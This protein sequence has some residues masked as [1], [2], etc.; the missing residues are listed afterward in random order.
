MQVSTA[1]LTLVVGLLSGGFLFWLF[2]R[3]K[4]QRAAADAINEY[5]AEKATLTERLQS[6]EEQLRS[7]GSAFDKSAAECADLR[8]QITEEIGKRISAEEK[9]SRLPEIEGLLAAKQQQVSELGSETQEL[10]GKI[11]MLTSTIENERQSTQEKLLLVKQAETNL[12]DTFKA[13][14]A[15]ALQTNNQ[16]FLDLAKTA[17]EKFQ[18]GARSDLELRQRCI[19]DLVKPLKDSLQSVDTKIHE[20]EKTRIDAYATLTEQ[21]KS[22]VSSQT[23]LHNE[24]QNLVKALRAPTVR[25]RW[26]EIQLKRVVEM[27]G[28]LEHCDFAQQE[29]IETEDGRLRPDMIVNLPNEKRIIVDSKAPLQ[30][31][32]EAIEATDEESRIQ[33]MRDHARQVRTH[34]TKLASRAY[35]D[36]FD[37]SP[38]F[39]VLFLPGEPFFSAALEQDPTLIEAGVEQRVILATPTTLI[40]LLRAVAYGWKQ[41]RLAANAQAISSLGKTLYERIRVLAG[42]FAEIRKGLDKTVDSYNRAVGS[43][44]SRVLVTARKFQDL[45]ASDEQEI[46][47]LEI[48]VPYLKPVSADELSPIP[49]IASRR[50]D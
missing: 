20:L 14:S 35:W 16:S 2:L 17:L 29:T 9:V 31:Y 30:A 26:G 44:E 43:F 6:R 23:N 39:V 28:M 7:L 13:L 8:R 48:A 32:L 33:H 42:H 15:E 1:E 46:Q 41:E 50:H 45:G 4:I 49:R 3:I 37:S 47:Q 25:G 22:L 12:V 11:I 27:A 10:R 36:Q 24:T 18:D 21:V 40:S 34:M 38:E 5:K 19:D